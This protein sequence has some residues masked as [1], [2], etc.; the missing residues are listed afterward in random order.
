MTLPPRL[1]SWPSPEQTELLPDTLAGDSCVRLIGRSSTLAALDRELFDRGAP[2]FDSWELAASDMWRRIAGCWSGTWQTQGGFCHNV[3]C[4]GA[5]ACQFRTAEDLDKMHSCCSNSFGIAP[6][7][8]YDFTFF[9]SPLG[10]PMALTRRKGLRFVWQES[11]GNTFDFFW[12]GDLPSHNHHGLYSHVDERSELIP[13]SA[14]VPGSDHDSFHVESKFSP[15]NMID[16]CF[17]AEISADSTRLRGIRKS[18]TVAEILTDPVRQWPH[19]LDMCPPPAVSATEFCEYPTDWVPMWNP[20]K[21][22]LNFHWDIDLAFARSIWD[23]GTLSPLNLREHGLRPFVSKFEGSRL[24]A[25]GKGPD[26]AGI[27]TAAA[28]FVGAMLLCCLGGAL[29]LMLWHHCTHKANGSGLGKLK[30]DGQSDAAAGVKNPAHSHVESVD[31]DILDIATFDIAHLKALGKIEHWFVESDQLEIGEAIGAGSFGTV[32]RA[33]AYQLTPVAV[34]IASSGSARAD[35]WTF[36]NEL[37]V[38][39]RVRHANIVLL[40]GFALLDG[41]QLCIVL[42]WVDGTTLARYIPGQPAASL[43][44]LAIDVARGMQYIHSQRPPILHRDLKPDNVLVKTTVEPPDAKIADFGLAVLVREGREPS[45]RAGTRRYMAPEVLA[46]QPYGTPADVYSFGQVLIC[47]FTRLKPPAFT[48]PEL[49]ASEGGMGLDSPNSGL[50]EPLWPEVFLPYAPQAGACIFLDPAARQ[51]MDEALRRMLDAATTAA[52]AGEPECWVGL[53]PESS[54]SCLDSGFTAFELN[55]CV[56]LRD[57]LLDLQNW[58]A[59][60][61]CSQIV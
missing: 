20:S 48:S 47:I 32:Y 59:A 7:H 41:H 10:Y 6:P 46:K 19:L 38:L 29:L 2:A 34:K 3:T 27:S 56:N 31:T 54:A 37:R 52:S 50:A 40:Q 51:T 22:D 39:R 24:L 36:A 43:A 12:L 44:K 14:I 18:L 15:F 4:V 16:S 26:R 57:N 5:S 30:S 21:T 1:L 60:C 58:E 8:Q 11:S 9:M 53:L 42:E 28:A 17:G 13:I 61:V 55:C 49:S 23:L 35:L 33:K 25:L 45:S